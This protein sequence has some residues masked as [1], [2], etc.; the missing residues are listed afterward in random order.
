MTGK[1]LLMVAAAL[2]AAATALA[3]DDF[4]WL[5]YGKTI[6]GRDGSAT[7]PLTIKL[8]EFPG[9][10]IPLAMA[11]IKAYCSKDGEA[12]QSVPLED[13]LVKIKAGKTCRHE[14]VVEAEADELCTS[15]RA[16]VG[17]PVYDDP[18]ERGM[19]RAL[20]ERYR[21]ACHCPTFVGDDRRARL[22]LHEMRTHN[23]AGLIH[24]NLKGCHPYDLDGF[25]LEREVKGAG[26][27]FIKIETGY[28]NEDER[29]VLLRLEAFKELL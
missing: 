29:N 23:I 22:I 16:L 2:V 19:L 7:L 11:N 25:Q 3:G 9:R 24:H 12:F 20:A 10:E 13:G 5:S 8:G 6:K 26:L 18:S 21:L 27:P 1:P 15:E 14:V 28:S 17:A 4:L